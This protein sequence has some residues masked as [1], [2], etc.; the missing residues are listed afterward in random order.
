MCPCGSPALACG[1][2]RRCV[3][4]CS[5][6]RLVVHHRAPGQNEPNLLVTLC[7][8]CHVRLHKALWKEQ[9][10]QLQLELQ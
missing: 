4:C 9:P 10:V 5:P 3:V 7:V 1:L 6:S 8:R 2:C